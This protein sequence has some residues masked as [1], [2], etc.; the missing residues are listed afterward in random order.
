MGLELAQALARLDVK[1]E[2]FEQ[3]DHFGGLRDAEVAKKLGA[4]LGAEFPVHLGVTLDVAREK[5]A[6]RVTWSGASA[7]STSF[8]RVLVAAGRPPELNYLNLQ[9][10]GLALDDRGIPRFDA[11][12]LQ[13]GDAP[14]FLAGDVDGQRPVLP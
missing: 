14:I 7:G 5:D 8:D 9:S 2:V 1:T 4:I 11:A 10:T 12:S 6:A 3:S 13:C